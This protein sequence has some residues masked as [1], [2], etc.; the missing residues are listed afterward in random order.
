M[1]IDINSI[2]YRWKGIYSPFLSYVDGYVVYQNGNALVYRGGT[3]QNFALGQQDATLAGQLAVGGV[4]VGGS[5]GQVLHVTGT[6][7]VSFQFE[8]ERSGTI[9][10]A[11]MNTYQGIGSTANNHHMQTLMNEGMVR[12]WGRNY[13]GASGIGR[14]DDISF[15][16]PGRVAFGSNAPRVVS[17]KAGYDNVYYI[18]SDGSLWVTGRGD[19]YTNGLG[20]NVAQNIPA[21]LSGKGDLGLNTVVT[22]VFTAFD[23]YGM[24]RVGC[25]DSNGYVYFWGT[26]NNYGANG[27][28]T[29]ANSQIPK[30]VPWSVQNPCKDVWMSAGQ[31]SAT[32]FVTLDGRAYMAGEVNSTGLGAGDKYIPTRFAPWDTEAPVKKYASAESVPHWIGSGYYRDW[33]VLLENGNLYLWGDDSGQVGGGWGDGTTGDNYPGT[34][35]Y[36]KLVMTDVKDFWTKSGGYHASVVLMNDGTVKATGAA[37]ANVNGYAVDTTTWSTIGGSYLTNVTKILGLGGLYW[38]TVMALRSD[39]K[40]VGWGANDDGHLGKGDAITPDW[41]VPSTWDFVKLNKPVVDFQYSGNCYGGVADVTVHYLCS[42]GSVYA[43][44]V[45]T[46]GQTGSRNDYYNYTPNQIIF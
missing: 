41:A 33:G 44:G 31:Y 16:K 28:G 24:P 10:T 32:M 22:K 17:M 1:K 45:G 29:T 42:D 7:S 27:W 11:L 37:S 26:W 4:S 20:T 39:G 38:G 18:M 46:Y 40:C 36:P 14:P 9:A 35:G 25:L 23:Y 15:N 13:Y 30:V 43:S 6:N 2:G 34:A 8:G 5:W 21:K 12:T 3:F 19:D